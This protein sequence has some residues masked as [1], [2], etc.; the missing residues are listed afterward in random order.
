MAATT[1]AQEIQR[2]QGLR[3]RIRTKLV[4]FGLVLSDAELDS[5][6]T[7]IEAIV[8][9]GAVAGTIS[10]KETQ[11]IIPAGYHNGSGSVGIA[12][13]EKEKIIPENIRAGRTVLGVP[14]GYA[15]EDAILQEKTATPTPAQQVISPDEGYDGL[16][17]V[18][19][20]AIP[21]NYADISHVTATA[22]DVLANKTFVGAD[23][24]EIAGTMQ[25]NGAVN[26]SID[27]LT[28]T[29]YTVPAGFHS[30]TGKVVLTDDIA[31]ALAAI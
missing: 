14:G 8:G 22:P 16:S 7:A 2:L 21:K 20:E 11:Y 30:G 17:S 25:N 31:N 19:V 1:P 3:D 26:A 12:P 24:T 10:D 23:G 6:T 9:N 4:S 13:A 18:T 29:E 15:G 5:C 28:T 27:G